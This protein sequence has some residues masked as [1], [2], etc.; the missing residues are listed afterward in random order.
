MNIIGNRLAREEIRALRM[1]NLYLRDE[2]MHLE[3][4]LEE[5]ERWR[6]RV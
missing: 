4:R 6:E 2:M 5:L 3:R 1:Q